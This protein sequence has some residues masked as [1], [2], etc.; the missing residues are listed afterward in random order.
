MSRHY[1]PIKNGRGTELIITENDYISI[2]KD[3]TD[4]MMRCGRELLAF[5]S[6]EDMVNAINKEKCICYHKDNDFQYS[7]LCGEN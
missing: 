3:G 1:K 7:L 6:F 5:N 4:I 2:G